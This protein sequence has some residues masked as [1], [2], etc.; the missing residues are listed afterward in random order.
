MSQDS[1]SALSQIRIVLVEPAG[2]LNV[3][4]AAR[5][6]KNFGL[7]HLILVK[8]QCNPLGEEAMQM[9][10]HAKDLL[11]NA[12]VVESIPAA[13]DGCYGAIATTARPRDI[14]TPLELPEQALGSLVADAL[15]SAS[16]PAGAQLKGTQ[17]LIFGPEDRGLSNEE[18]IHAQRFVKI[19][20][21]PDY[22]ALNLAQAVA[23]CC[24]ELYRAAGRAHRCAPL[25]DYADMNRS[26]SGQN[27]TNAL[28]TGPRSD[29]QTE[30]HLQNEDRNKAHLE[31]GSSQ[32][33]N[34]AKLN[35]LEGYY[36]HLESVLLSV[37]Y[38][39]PHTAASRMRKVRQLLQRATPTSAE[40][41]LL[42]G[43]LRQVE[44]ALSESKKG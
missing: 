34:Q 18:L 17:A 23:V 7:Q 29:K 3:G 14:N 25:R 11:H 28:R 19:P 39:Y 13:L 30:S 40:V 21:N 38:L 4:S 26:K 44:W 5:V 20:A 24:Y 12:R 35:E 1:L 36:Q 42:R 27:L 8:P 6:M 22:S 10:V 41:S 31:T 16:E 2:P 33:P 32:I 9:A 15:A 43:M 37:E